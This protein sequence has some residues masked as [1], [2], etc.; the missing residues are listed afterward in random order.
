[1]PI[2]IYPHQCCS[3]ISLPWDTE[4]ELEEV[5]FWRSLCRCRADRAMPSHDQ[6]SIWL[7]FQWTLQAL[8]LRTSWAPLHSFTY[9]LYP[10]NHGSGQ[11]LFN[12]G[13]RPHGLYHYF[14]P[15][16]RC[17]NNTALFL[18]LSLCKRGGLPWALHPF[19]TFQG[20]HTPPLL[21]FWPTLRFGIL[22][23]TAG[24]LSPGRR[25]QDLNLN[26][27]YSPRGE[28]PLPS[29][30]YLSLKINLPAEENENTQ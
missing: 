26:S 27:L 20:T 28:I 30:F 4:R 3:T 21:P 2:K 13:W 23:R 18:T 1:M 8:R 25:A 17:D 22:D 16:N 12:W 14:S 15:R 29:L 10:E 11:D 5:P 9:L 7:D 19:S 24:N 6:K